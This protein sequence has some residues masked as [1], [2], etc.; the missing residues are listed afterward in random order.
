VA[1]DILRKLDSGNLQFVVAAHLSQTTN[2]PK[3]VQQMWAEVLTPRG[4]AFDIACQTEGFAWI[5][6][7]SQQ[8]AA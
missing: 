3:V 5:S 7:D 8:V 1:C 6:L 4:I 2:C